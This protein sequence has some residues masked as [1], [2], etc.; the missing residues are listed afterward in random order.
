MALN[1]VLMI[2]PQL[3]PPKSRW[4]G[5]STKYMKMLSPAGGVP[6]TPED[7]KPMLLKQLAPEYANRINVVVMDV[8]LSSKYSDN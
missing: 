8:S 1:G 4:F 3:K 7:L 2:L 5:A 6:K